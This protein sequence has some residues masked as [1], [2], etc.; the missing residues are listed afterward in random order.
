[1]DN[2]AQPVSELMPYKPQLKNAPQEGRSL[3]RDSGAG[4]QLYVTDALPKEG[5]DR[6]TLPE[7]LTK[8]PKNKML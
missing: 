6:Q 5:S 1:L 8:S 7:M 2:S 3:C 4:L